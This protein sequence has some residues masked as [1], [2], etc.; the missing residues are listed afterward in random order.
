MLST[1]LWWGAMIG[2]S[3]LGVGSAVLTGMV[4]SAVRVVANEM[5]ARRVRSHGPAIVGRLGSVT[6]TSWI[7]I[8]GGAAIGLV[9]VAIIAAACVSGTDVEIDSSGD[10]VGATTG[11]EGATQ[12]S[13]T[14]TVA[15]RGESSVGNDASEGIDADPAPEL[16]T[17]E[18]NEDGE[19]TVAPQEQPSDEPLDPAQ[20]S[21]LLI[22]EVMWFNRLDEPGA[23]TF[24]DIAAASERQPDPTEELPLLE[25][26]GFRGG[27]AR[28]FRNDTQDVVISQVYE[29]GTAQDA[30]FYMEDGFITLTGFDVEIFDVDGFEGVRGFRQDGEDEIGPVVNYGLAFTVENK[31]YLLTLTGDPATA[32]LDILVGAMTDQERLA[33]S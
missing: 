15:D 26:R 22:P 3:L 10:S 17:G 28:V 30:D 19:Q 16:P 7:S 25:T 12:P 33:N 8:D 31:W 23:D 24:L 13:V 1:W 27:W 29:F 21:A 32:T 20:L 4:F 18:Q 6:R 2:A 9:A 14:A 11:V 5:L